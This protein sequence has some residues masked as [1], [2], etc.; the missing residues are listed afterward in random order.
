MS[1]DATRKPRAEQRWPSGGIRSIS[2]LH[3]L[4]RLRHS[5]RCWQD[6]GECGALAL[7]RSN[8]EPSPG[9]LHDAPADGKPE[10]DPLLLRREE[11]REELVE[12]LARQS[13]AV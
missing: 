13:G 8:I 10:A 12:H 4:R 11:R 9:R 5:R 7:V 3:G 6:H 1:E 2:A